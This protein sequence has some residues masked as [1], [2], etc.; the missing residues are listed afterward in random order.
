MRLDRV[1]V[2][3]RGG[4]AAATI[5][6]AEPEWREIVAF[7]DGAEAG[8]REERCM[9]RAAVARLEHI[10]GTQTP[11]H[12]DLAKNRINPAGD[13]NMDCL[14]E[15]ANTTTYLRLIAERGLL[16]WHDVLHRVHRG[17]LY[18]DTHNSAAIRDRVNG[19]IFVVDSWYLDN[20]EPP[21]IQELNEWLAK[22]P[23][24]DE[25]P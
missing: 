21:Y 19:T 3:Y 16:K 22:T 10:A 4:R 13:G 17:P 25:T 7:F 8:P 20:G 23:F 6:I 14:D 1:P 2:S 15:S 24:P 5:R 11:T 9:I 12:R 18:F